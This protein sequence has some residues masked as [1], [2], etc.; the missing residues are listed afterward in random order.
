M[1]PIIYLVSIGAGLIVGSFLNVVVLRFNTGWTLQGRS[2]CLSC[3]HQLSWLE[4]VPV[5]SFLWQRGHCRHCGSQISSQYIT[6][7]L[8]TALVFGLIAW[9]AVTDIGLEWFELVR[10]VVW[11]WAVASTLVV[12]AAYDLKHK[13]I[14]DQLVY[15]FMALSALSGFVL[16]FDFG[17]AEIVWLVHGLYSG[18]LLFL[19]FWALWYFSA[20]RLMGFGDAKLVFGLGLWLGLKDALIGVMLAFILGA[21]VGLGLIA[22]R[23][24]K[25]LPKGWRLLSLKSE[26]PFAPFLVTGAFISFILNLGD[27][28]AG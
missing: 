5:V 28:L 10:T 8:V 6:V 22:L 14:P 20:G 3:S 2:R 7:E 9:R 24:S 21:V 13:I 27:V 17:I 12:I 15:L 19:A 16:N 1:I 25:N 18:G 4:L 23:R 26:I 11:T